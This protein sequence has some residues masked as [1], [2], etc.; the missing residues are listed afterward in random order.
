MAPYKE[1]LKNYREWLLKKHKEAEEI[2]SQDR[3]TPDNVKRLIYIYEVSADYVDAFFTR[4]IVWT[5]EDLRKELAKKKAELNKP[6]SIFD[7]LYKKVVAE[8]AALKKKRL[9]NE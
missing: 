7:D 4:H 2:F 1:L 6:E 8:R 5:A 3:F 9:K